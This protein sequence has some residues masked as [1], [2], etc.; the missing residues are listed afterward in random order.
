MCLG[1]NY[2]VTGNP[3]K[4]APNHCWANKIEYANYEYIAKKAIELGID[5]IYNKGSKYGKT[6][7]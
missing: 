3:L 6:G 5:E 4:P 2:I 1:E 7:L